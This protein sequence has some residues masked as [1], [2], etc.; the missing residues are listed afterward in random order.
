MNNTDQ[1]QSKEKS[2]GINSVQ[3]IEGTPFW[4]ISKYKDEEL[5]EKYVVYGKYTILQVDIEET[6]TIEEIL[7][8]EKWNVTNQMMLIIAS[9]VKDAIEEEFNNKEK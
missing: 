5:V 3:G 6:K 2:N 8:K 4:L 7:E 9:A 1:L